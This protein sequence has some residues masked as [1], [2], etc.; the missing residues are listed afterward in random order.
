LKITSAINKSRRLTE[1]LTSG[2][3][4]SKPA[5]FGQ[6]L[7]FLTLLL[8]IF[9]GK[10]SWL[11]P[12]AFGSSIATVLVPFITLSAR[13]I[14]QIAPSKQ[15]K[16]NLKRSLILVFI[17]VFAPFIFCA[18]YLVPYDVAVWILCIASINLGIPLYNMVFG[19]AIR[20]G[21]IR[22]L[23]NL[24]L[25]ANILVFVFTVFSL[26]ADSGPISLALAIGFG[27]GLPSSFVLFKLLKQMSSWSES[28]EQDELTQG[29]IF[30]NIAV[31]TL[32]SGV[33]QSY[34]LVLPA[35]GPYS[36]S[37]AL[38]CRI[39]SGFETIGGVVMGPFLEARTLQAIKQPNLALF[40][41]AQ[42]LRR[43]FSVVLGLTSAAFTLTILWLDS[44]FEQTYV[45]DWRTFLT[46]ASLYAFCLAYLAVSGPL[47]YVLRHELRQLHSDA[48]KSLPLLLLLFSPA[49]ENLL[50][51]ISFSITAATLVLVSTHSQVGKKFFGSTERGAFKRLVF[52]FYNRIFLNR[53]IQIVFLR[54][55]DLVADK[56]T[57]DEA[58]TPTQMLYCSAFSGNI[59]DQAMADS[60]VL[61]VKG[62]KLIIT[63]YLPNEKQLAFY[64]A[65]EAKVKVIKGLVLFPT[66]QR[67]RALRDLSKLI[68]ASSSFSMVGAD[69]MDGG[70]SS[71]E[72]LSRMSIL[73]I[74]NKHQIPTRVLGFSW[75]P[76]APPSLVK[77][78]S[79]IGRSTQLFVR[80]PES[81][82]QLA[83]LDV[84]GIIQS[85]D[86]AFAL[87]PDVLENV[88]FD[89]L[90]TPNSAY[91]CLNVSALISRR[92][93]S[94]DGFGQIVQEL[95]ARGLK[96]IFLPHVNTGRTNNDITACRYVFEKFGSDADILVDAILSPQEILSLV[97]NSSIV[98]TGRMHLAILSMLVGI[99]AITFET[100]NKVKGLYKLFGLEDL[101]IDP[102][103]AYQDAV[104]K[105]IQ[106][107]LESQEAQRKIQRVLPE[108][109]RTAA[110]N[111][112]G[113]SND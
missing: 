44:L 15:V 113:I 73:R 81:F 93:G 34:A 79:K 52:D 51:T 88:H 75:R 35:L 110:E 65:N 17:S 31:S 84:D 69:V 97:R 59:G 63:P 43:A 28:S 54:V 30:R 66:L 50:L 83:A 33:H 14:Y 7:A 96:V 109:K 2:L 18:A 95:H 48:I 8:P 46:A 45:P 41:A 39:V 40:K 37:W 106:F 53:L 1:E 100:Q 56:K 99:P 76:D 9:A 23:S 107:V 112:S 19:L 111:F 78:F 89:R 20:S 57:S 91:A 98:I 64:W 29:K 27:F 11:A 49:A 38:V 58:N 62:P 5:L 90:E 71:F 86:S 55:D 105:Q 92:G 13:T 60:F 24:R 3:D 94:Q 85:A 32:S 87:N 61:S 21:A 108:L 42:R 67:L 4:G 82:S 68:A 101:V 80:D 104:S 36:A 74:A 102:F 22:S 25:V 77:T 12:L 72:S 70:Y 103:S 6:A 47:L 26:L 16:S 10:S